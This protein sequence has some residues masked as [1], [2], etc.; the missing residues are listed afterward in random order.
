VRVSIAAALALLTLA[1]PAA[2][3]VRIV[4]GFDPADYAVALAR[5]G[6]LDSPPM[7]R[8]AL[9]AILA[10]VMT[11]LA[12]GVA[13]C[14][15]GEE[16]APVAETVEGTLPEGTSEEEPASTIEGDAA[17]GEEVWATGQC[18]SCHTLAAA[19][20]SGTI[21]PNL[22]ESKP[23]LELAVD[24]VTNGS[25]AM[26]PFKGQLDPKQIADVAAFVVQSTSG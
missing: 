25:G 13:A 17:A 6:P 7:R 9:I 18:G 20:S 14:G 2:A 26:P 12:L 1:A 3:G 23:P 16:V 21:G 8:P 19:N 10:L 15:G 4:P 11:T 24:R 5:A 22:D